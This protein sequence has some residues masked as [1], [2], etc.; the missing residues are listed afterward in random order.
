MI[1]RSGRSIWSAANGTGSDRTVLSEY[2]AVGSRGGSFMI[3]NGRYKYIHYSLYAAQLFDLEQDPNEQRDLAQ[4]EAHRHIRAD[5]EQG[6]RRML[7]PGA[8]DA[9]ARHD[10]TQKLLTHGLERRMGDPAAMAAELVRR[11]R[12]PG[13]VFHLDDVET[14]DGVLAYLFAYLPHLDIGDMEHE[15]GIRSQLPE[16]LDDALAHCLGPDGQ[17]SEEEAA[18]IRLKYFDEPEPMSDTELRRRLGFTRQTLRNRLKRAMAK[19]ALCMK[20]ALGGERG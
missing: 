8:V 6:L 18:A 9:Q 20:G 17:L 14:V 3:R 12:D 10:Q 7:D 13:C 11:H 16:G 2:H 15:L 4:C 1:S 5:A 19:L